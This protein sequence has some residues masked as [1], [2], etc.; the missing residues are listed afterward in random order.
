MTKEIGDFN[1]S[2]HSTE[3]RTDC[4]ISFDC[5]CG[6][7]IG[8]CDYDPETCEVCNR[9]YFY[10]R[11]KGK[12]F[13]NENINMREIEGKIKRMTEEELFELDHLISHIQEKMESKDYYQCEHCQDY[14]KDI[15]KHKLRVHKIKE[16]EK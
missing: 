8:L 10:D 12:V 3:E 15:K 2:D 13:F 1:F 16:D 5:V 14:F 4:Y 11:E 7:G 6:E 9:Y